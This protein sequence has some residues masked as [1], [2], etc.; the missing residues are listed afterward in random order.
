MAPVIQDTYPEDISICFGCGRNNPKGWQIR[1]EWDGTEGTLRFTPE[2]H[3]TAYP[4]IVYGGLI[5]GL[6][7]CHSVGTAVAAMYQAEN[8]PMGSQPP[9]LCVTANLNVTYIKPTPLGN[10]LFLRARIKELTPK[11]AIVHCSLYAGG[12]ECDR[13]EVVA[14]RVPPDR[15][16]Q[17]KETR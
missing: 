13:A 14:V 17:V 16:K 9:I 8:R 3:H 12:D 7:D 4:G 5:A 15:L 10:E 11:K 6:I 2:A 1:S